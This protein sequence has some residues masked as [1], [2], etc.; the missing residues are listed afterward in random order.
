M[1][2][3]NFTSEIPKAEELGRVFRDFRKNRSLSLKQISDEYVS[4]SLISRFERGESDIS[5]TKFLRAL[6]NM[7]VEVNEFFDAANGYRKTEIIAFMSQLVPLEYRR[8]IEGF[9]RLFEEQKELYRKNPSVYQYHLNMILAQGFICKC[10]ESIP[11]PVE[12]VDE[13]ADYL[14]SVEVWNIYELILIGNLYLFFNTELL[15][16]MGQEIVNNYSK[17]EANKG[18]VIITLLNIF[19]ILIYRNELVAA[20]YYKG[21]IL[22]M[23]ENETLLYER[24]IHHFLTGLLLYKRGEKDAGMEAM[25]KSIQIYQWLGCE[26]LAGN[27]RDALKKNTT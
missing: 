13:I 27:Y 6:E 26:S 15:H 5:I 18:L 8:D 1:R 17:K 23:L 16:K 14:F 10:D 4:E 7:R 9:Q 25:E 11:F 19:E 12:Y 20:E 22:P 21:A 24:N 3:S 2:D